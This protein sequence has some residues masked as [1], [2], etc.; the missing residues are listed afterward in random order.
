[1]NIN[2]LKS[3]LQNLNKKSNKGS[4][5]V[6]KPKDEHVVRALKNPHGDLMEEVAFHYNVGDA[7]QILCPKKNFG[8][9][10]AVCDFAD[11]LRSWKDEKGRDKPERVRKEDF[12]IFKKI[13]ANSKMFIPIVVRGE[14]GKTVVDEAKW[15]GLTA[16]QAQQVLDV[17]TDTDRLEACGIDPTDAE[18]ATEVLT[19]PKKAFDLQVSYAKP[20]EK[21]NTKTFTNITVKAKFKTSPLTGDASK[22][23][24]II[25]KI[26]K[27]AEVFPEVPSADVQKALEKFIGAG[28]KESKPEGGDEKYATKSKEDAKKPGAKGRTVDEAFDDLDEQ[29]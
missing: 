21:G 6:W 17:C 8:K 29:G 12:E 11:S 25:V 3:K 15:W 19:S 4:N 22:D 14:D 2:E 23:E 13:Q 7:F 24:A 26:K 28:M 10:C 1:M 20:G 27:I 18:R 9:D 5:D 16:N